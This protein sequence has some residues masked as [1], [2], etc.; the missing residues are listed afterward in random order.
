MIACYVS[1][2][3]FGHATRCAEV[4][5]ALRAADPRVP[6]AVVAAA[7][8]W[9]FRTA[10]D[11][12][13]E[14]R[15]AKNDVGL[16][17]RDA[18]TIDLQATLAAWDAGQA[19]REARTEEEAAFLVACGARLVL[20]DVPPLAFAA[21]ARAGVPAFGLANFTWDWI[22]RHYAAQDGR[23]AEL[24]D[25]CAADYAQADALLELPFACDNA[26]FARREPIPLVARRPRSGREAVRERL[27]LGPEPVVLLSFGG[28]GLDAFELEA[29]GSMRDLRF[30]TAG[31]WSRLPANGRAVPH[32]E[33][34]RVGCGYEGL[35]AAADVVVSKP[36]YGIVTDAIGAGTRLLYADRGDFPEYPVLVR[37]MQ[38]WLTCAHVPSERLRVGAIEP[39]LRA[40]LARPVTPPPR[41]DGAEV[42]A[43]RLLAALA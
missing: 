22:Y 12:P 36:G 24:A 15:S 30:L 26:A 19:E 2:H 27:G 34:D 23:F 3:G 16:G 28:V 31:E 37:D 38:P 14:F 33:L 1:S 8:E 9:L 42:A 40:L 5:R 4:L 10:I 11:G 29:L 39:E 18:L 6:L 20:A 32:A 35:V 43:A 41:V 7:P 13:F 25:A 21:A 17:Q